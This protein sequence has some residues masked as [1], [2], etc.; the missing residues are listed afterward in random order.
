MLSFDE[1]VDREWDW[2]SVSQGCVIG[3]I[4]SQSIMLSPSSGFPTKLVAGDEGTELTL[5]LNANLYC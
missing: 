1:L 5:D 2:E 4:L 3:K